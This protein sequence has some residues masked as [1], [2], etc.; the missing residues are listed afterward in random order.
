M[1]E[2]YLTIKDVMERL[3]LGRSSVYRRIADGTLPA[4]IQI[5][6][7]RRFKQSEVEAAL[8][9]LAYKRAATASTSEE[10]L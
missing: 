9:E 5:G 2:K 4:P 6:H 1:T 8:S 10:S 7:L 3:N